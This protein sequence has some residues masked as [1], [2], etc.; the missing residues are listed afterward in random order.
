MSYRLEP[1]GQPFTAKDFWSRVAETEIPASEVVGRGIVEGAIKSFGLGTAYRDLTT[2]ELAPQRPNRFENA[3]QFQRRR[4]DY[5]EMTEADWKD[6]AFARDGLTWEPGMT[7][8]RA[9]VLADRYDESRYRQMVL[10][11]AKGWGFAAGIGGQFLGSALDPINYVPV[12]GPATRAAAAAKF[13]LIAGTALTAAGDAALNTAVAGIATRAARADYGDDVSWTGFA[14]DVAMGALIGGAFGTGLGAWE[15]LRFNRTANALPRVAEAQQSLSDAAGDIVAGR[16]ISL[17][18][19]ALDAIERTSIEVRPV[20]EK[21]NAGRALTSDALR[22]GD[23]PDGMAKPDSI[24][25]SADT[26]ERPMAW[27]DEAKRAEIFPEPLRT[28][29]AAPLLAQKGPTAEVVEAYGRGEIPDGWLVHGRSGRADLETGHAIQLSESLDVAESYS[30]IST[31]RGGG[32][33]WYVRPILGTVVIDARTS[34]GLSTIE[35]AFRRSF[36]DG[37]FPDQEWL[38]EDVD[39]AWEVASAQFAPED[40]VNSAA[41]YDNERWIEWLYENTGAQFVRT[42]DGGVVLD[43]EAVESIR[44]DQPFQARAF[45]ASPPP[46]APIDPAVAPAAAAV[47]KP[48]DDIASDLGIDTET[49]QIGEEIELEQ[50]RAAGRLSP[51]DEAALAAADEDIV[52]ADLIAEALRAAAACNMR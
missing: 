27:G 32:S 21:E 44:A 22:R 45:D 9:Q 24:V 7:L 50:L 14:T 10:S 47:G 18:P 4:S 36:E 49:G 37:T 30:G 34:E 31:G 38:P 20:Q 23:A 46:P 51:S 6:S 41:A 16:D 5:D 43:R 17:P 8:Q 42:P 26:V 48:A 12:L 3:E 29:A 1:S 15:R 28:E 11:N 19:G 39:K 52:R 33:L 2:P 13:G 25:A 35:P 40:I